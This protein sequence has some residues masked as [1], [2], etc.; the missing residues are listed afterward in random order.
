[1]LASL[2]VIA[3]VYGLPLMNGRDGGQAVME[4]FLLP[5]YVQ[6]SHL[7]VQAGSFA[8]PPPMGGWAPL[9]PGW[10][11]AWA[12]ALVGGGFSAWLYLS[13]LPR[14]KALPPVRR[15][16]GLVRNK[17]YVDELYDAVIIRP[18][19][20]G[21]FV[22][23]R[24]VDSLLIDRVAVRGVAWVTYQVG[25]VIRYFQTGDAQSYAAVMAAAVLAA[26]AYAFYNFR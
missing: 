10:G 7:G 24:V 26:V 4:N 15:L 2:S 22:L 8:Q 14:E 19:K 3:L 12:V 5:V 1:M 20:F 23:Y 25:S 11:L 16:Q 18:V 6:T 9:I 21:S 13:V 17:F